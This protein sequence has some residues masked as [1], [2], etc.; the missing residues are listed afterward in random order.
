MAAIDD[1]LTLIGDQRGP[2]AANRLCEACVALYG[3]R[4]A[5]ISIVFDGANVGTLGASGATAREL[6]ELQFTLGEGPCL[7]AVTQRIPI[8]VT[9]LADPRMQQWPAYGPALLAHDIRGVYAVPVVVAGQHIGALDL[10]QTQPGLLGAQQLTGVLVAADLAQ[11]P[12]LDLLGANLNAAVNDPASDAWAELNT[13]SH[14]EVSQATGVLVAQLDVAP[15]VA[16]LRLRAHA[17]AT[18]RGVTEIA[19]DILAHRL[20]LEAD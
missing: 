20:E 18:G 12:F 19:R 13:L 1:L 8:F 16:L 3:V 6:D 17:Y 10:F 14:P 5:A 2:G 9:D 4:A 11:L 15:A 7:D